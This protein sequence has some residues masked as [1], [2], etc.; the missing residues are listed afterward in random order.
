MDMTH[1]WDPLPRWSIWDWP[2]SYGTWLIHMGHDWF[3]WDMTHSWDPLPP[4]SMV[5]LW[6]IDEVIS[7][8]PH[9]FGTY[10]V[11]SQYETGLIHMGHDSYMRHDPFIWDMTQSCDLHPP[12][13][14]THLCV[15]DKVIKDMP[16]SYGTCLIHMGHASFIWDMPHS[17]GTCLIHMGHASFMPRS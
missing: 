3:I 5:Y 12:W 8:M 7:D 11:H 6:V 1:S 4:W 15:R 2:H 10:L 16:H 13:S 17:Y 9:S 14:M